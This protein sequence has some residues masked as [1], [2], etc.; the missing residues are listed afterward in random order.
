M[1]RSGFTVKSFKFRIYPHPHQARALA[2]LFGCARVVWNDALALRQEAWKERQEHLSACDLMKVCITQARQT[3]E[4]AWLQEV[5]TTPLQQSIRDLEQ[6]Y[7]NW[8]RSLKG[9]G[10]SNPPRFKSRRNRQTARFTR[11]F[12]RCRDR[13][14]RLGK[15][16]EV[17]IVWSRPLPGVPTSVTV[18]KD[19]AGRYFASFVVEVARPNTPFVHAA[20]GIDLGLKT[21]VTA[22]DG[23]K[24]PPPKFLRRAHR[25]RRRLQRN[26]A[27]KQKGSNRYGC[28][29][30]L[31]AKLLAKVSDRRLDFLH[32]LSTRIIRENQTVVLEDLN[33]Q[34]LARNKKLARS[35]MDSGWRTFRRLLELKAKEYGKECVAIN[36]WIPTSQTCSNCGHDDGWK[37]PSIR[38]WRCPKCGAVHDRDVNA[39]KN[40]LAAGLAERLNGRGAGHKTASVAA[41]CEASTHL[42]QGN[43]REEKPRLRAG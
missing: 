14:V 41:G 37:K 1:A 43:L 20:V 10:R 27:R 32:K 9:K 13:T 18:V 15:V 24:V 2:R 36:R 38:Q 22:S 6:S 16:G 30:L 29:R 8:W 7:R 23:E 31:V 40:I 19:C 26:L 21:F 34:G 39:A 12:F 25:R 28:A 42:N 4:R 33:V 35:I 3:P 17:P 11:K 5:H